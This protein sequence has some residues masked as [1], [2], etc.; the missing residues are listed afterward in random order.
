MAAQ[1]LDILRNLM[2]KESLLLIERIRAIGENGS[3]QEI[4]N[5]A[6]DFRK[7]ISVFFLSSIITTLPAEVLFLIFEKCRTKDLVRLG[8]TCKQFHEMINTE[9]MF[10]TQSIILWEQIF[11]NSTS[12]FLKIKQRALKSMSW[13]K[14]MKC[15]SNP[16]G[17]G[18]GCRI[19]KETKSI[20]LGKFTED[21][22]VTE[23]VCLYNC[24]SYAGVGD[25]LRQVNGNGSVYFSNGD[26]YHGQFQNSISH[27]KG[28]YIWADGRR[29]IG[30]FQNGV[31]S[32]TG[33]K[34]YCDGTT[35]NGGFSEGQYHGNGR[36]VWPDGSSYEGEWTNGEPTDGTQLVHPFLNRCYEEGRCTEAVT[37]EVMYPQNIHECSQCGSVYCTSCYEEKE[38]HSCDNATFTSQWLDS[39]CDCSRKECKERQAKR[40]KMS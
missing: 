35:Y 5:T 4:L 25:W 14:I 6:L 39:Y 30:T 31:H 36:L 7:S 10:Q 2:D 21:L 9:K 40:K 1:E 34:T 18:Y 37:Q 15:L 22:D 3:F 20:L 13:K 28:E 27:G 38:C 33:V 24:G 8:E 23:L 26:E 32:G 19:I 11:P 29:Y 16:R 12:E 17:E